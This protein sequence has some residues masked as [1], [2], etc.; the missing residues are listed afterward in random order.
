MNLKVYR[1]LITKTKRG[2]RSGF[3]PGKLRNGCTNVD[4]TFFGR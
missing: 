2:Q 4:G 3:V 1:V